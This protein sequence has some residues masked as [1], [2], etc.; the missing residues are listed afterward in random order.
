MVRPVLAAA[1][2]LAALLASGPALADPPAPTPTPTPVPSAS[3][4][5]SPTVSPT[6]TPTP[7]PPP[8][9]AEP[10]QP[11]AGSE[12]ETA[13]PI[14]WRRSRAVGRPWAGSLIRGVQ[15]PA[16]GR[17]YFTW[18]F[19]L[20]GV[21]NRP[22]RRWG[23]DRLVRTVLRVLREFRLAHPDA[24]R[25][26][27]GDLSR[28]RGGI[29]DKRFGG[30]GHASHQN[31][32]DVDVYYPRRDGLELRPG[33]PGQVDR[34]LAQALVDGFVAAGAE[35]VFV[36]PSLRLRGPRRIVSALVHHD[37]HLHVR[38]PQPRVSPRR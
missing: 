1:L 12:P 24:P 22:W 7:T 16:S 26:G 8:M 38:L 32:L 14:R 15:L 23:T 36:G 21:P 30:L 37:D 3:P 29:F 11:L 20:R 9:T 35:R 33:R 6:P 19:P 27:I 13:T 2:L 5:V 25:V 17:H 4:A 18:D 31:G 34:R 28:P 10:P